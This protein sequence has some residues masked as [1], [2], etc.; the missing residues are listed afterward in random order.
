MRDGAIAKATLKT[1]PT[2]ID[3]ANFIDTVP[4][5]TRRKDAKTL[6]HLT[7]EITGLEP[8]MWGLSIIGYGRYR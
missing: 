6:L 1:A 4:N 8:Q 5:D 3:P 2:T 7:A